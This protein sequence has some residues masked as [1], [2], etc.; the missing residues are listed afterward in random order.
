MSLKTL[1]P[2]FDE[3]AYMEFL[4]CAEKYL[5]GK[6]GSIEVIDNSTA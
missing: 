1:F 5:F 3:L 4:L 2:Y 6:V